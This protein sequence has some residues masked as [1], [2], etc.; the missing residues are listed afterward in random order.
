MS[1]AN[2]PGSTMIPFSSSGNINQL[3]FAAKADIDNLFNSRK[4]S[5]D[6]IFDTLEVTLNTKLKGLTDKG[7]KKYSIQNATTDCI[8]IQK[9]LAKPMMK[10]I[11]EVYEL[12]P[13]QLP[14]TST[15]TAGLDAA[16]NAYVLK[17]AGFK[18]KKNMQTDANVIENSR[19]LSASINEL[20][21]HIE[22]AKVVLFNFVLKKHEYMQ[23]M[24]DFSS[25]YYEAL[26]EWR[27]TSPP[28]PVESI[29]LSDGTLLISCYK[30]VMLRYI[31]VY[32]D[33][34][35]QVM[36]TFVKIE[37]LYKI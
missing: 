27:I 19:V 8:L 2:A 20:I 37:K 24:D 7:N 6:K 13:Q 29:L 23:F 34:F 5:I 36:N 25:G 31:A 30:A 16:Y 35:D 28:V 1:S 11:D 4:K 18:P 32:F 17:Y 22:D 9:T 12:L 26:E 3:L 14:V 10:Y 33:Q 15:V 21:K